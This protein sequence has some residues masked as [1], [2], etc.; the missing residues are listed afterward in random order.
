MN[1]WLNWRDIID[2][3]VEALEDLFNYVDDV[4]SPISLSY[5]SNTVSITENCS[6]SKLT[7]PLSSGV[8][9]NISPPERSLTARTISNIQR[10]WQDWHLPVDIKHN[11][12][13]NNP[14]GVWIIITLLGYLDNDHT[15]CLDLELPNNCPCWLVTTYTN[16]MMT[17]QP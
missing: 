15:D 12:F 1:C 6:S 13:R 9:V 4:L 17:K 8:M 10:V 5:P 2:V 7:M 3:L 14:T 16:R 11:L